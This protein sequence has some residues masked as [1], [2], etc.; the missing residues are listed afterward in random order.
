MYVS[1][2]QYLL[3]PMYHPKRKAFNSKETAESLVN[4]LN[5][6]L[7]ITLVRKLGFLMVDGCAVNRVA[8]DEAEGE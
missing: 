6:I 8:R 5:S 3:P 4:T 2:E 1:D 7:G